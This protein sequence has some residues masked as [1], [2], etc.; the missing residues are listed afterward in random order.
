MKALPQNED[1]KNRGKIPAT[2]QKDDKKMFFTYL[3]KQNRCE[4]TSI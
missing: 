2:E 1:F 4:N 3:T